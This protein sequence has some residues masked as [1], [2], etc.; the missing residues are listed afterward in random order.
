MLRRPGAGMDPHVATARRRQRGWWADPGAPW[1]GHLLIA[2]N[3]K[4]RSVGA[5]EELNMRSRT[6]ALLL[7]HAA[8]STVRVA[9]S[10]LTGTAV[11]A[12]TSLNAGLN[13]MS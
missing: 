9:A 11:K 8:P 5:P 2:M 13:P 1:A 7:P 10:V 3:L 6:H 4:F 12:G